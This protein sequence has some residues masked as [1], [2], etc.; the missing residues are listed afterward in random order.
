[1]KLRGPLKE[2]CIA[3]VLGLFESKAFSH[4]HCYWGPFESKA[5]HLYIAVTVGPHLKAR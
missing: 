4:Y 3:V 1:V 2:K 5:A